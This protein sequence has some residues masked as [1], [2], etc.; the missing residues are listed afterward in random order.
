MDLPKDGPAQRE[1]I[2]KI[3]RIIAQ[4]QPYVDEKL[5]PIPRITLY[6]VEKPLTWHFIKDS[7]P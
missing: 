5:D 4:V 1:V 6:Q 3:K 2:V 7:I